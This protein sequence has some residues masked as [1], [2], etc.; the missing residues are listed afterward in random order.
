MTAFIRNK[1]ENPGRDLGRAR[2]KCNFD[3]RQSH[4]QNIKFASAAQ[5]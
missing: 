3:W 5:A 2:A 1:E 4:V